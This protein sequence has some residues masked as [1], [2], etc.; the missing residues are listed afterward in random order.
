MLSLLAILV[1]APVQ[2][3]AISVAEFIKSFDDDKNRHTASKEMGEHI[4]FV[5]APDQSSDEIRSRLAEALSAS[6][7]KTESG[8]R[9]ERT[10]AQGEFLAKHEAEEREK[11]FRSFQEALR[12]R[13]ADNPSSE[14]RANAALQSLR[15][16][17]ERYRSTSPT[18]YTPATDFAADWL[19]YSLIEV[20]DPAAIAALPLM[21]DIQFSNKPVGSL[22]PLPNG[23]LNVL[24]I[25]GR[26]RRE[27]KDFSQT[28]LE[29]A[30][31][32]MSGWI[33]SRVESVSADKELDSV[34][35]QI[36]RSSNEFNAGVIVLDNKGEYFDAAFQ[37]FPS[38]EP[39]DRLNLSSL[40]TA[41]LNGVQRIFAETSYGY[42]FTRNPQADA[43]DRVVG[44]EPLCTTEPLFNAIALSTSR[45]LIAVLDDRLLEAAK[46]TPGH[47]KDVARF[48]R[49]AEDDGSLTW[50]NNNGWDVLRPR[51]LLDTEVRRFDRSGL[52]P[53]LEAVRKAGFETIEAHVDFAAAAPL[54]ANPVVT[55]VLGHLNRNG[56]VLV[57]EEL[58]PTWMA[59]VVRDATKLRGTRASDLTE[60][61]LTSLSAERRSEILDRARNALANLQPRPNTNPTPLEMNGDYALPNGLYADSNLRIVPSSEGCIGLS[62]PFPRAYDAQEFGYT[63]AL[64]KKSPAVMIAGPFW[65]GRRRT[66]QV[67]INLTKNGMIRCKYRESAD[68][69]VEIQTYESL[70]AEFRREAERYYDEARKLGLL[71]P[72]SLNLRGLDGS[73]FFK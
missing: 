46:A 2:D 14:E 5:H 65:Y 26:D 36:G 51:Y 34:I 64:S 48:V 55:A 35:L 21:A 59:R 25:Y 11:L 4:I 71:L 70:P 31:G 37:F 40:I 42:S 60:L 24:R 20:I 50:S 56:Y 7:R 19:L 39:K 22:R 6:W 73:E 43:I 41:E 61:P 10:N 30:E 18:S 17:Q 28:L 33:K 67:E 49:Y 27:I 72:A 53:F 23:A 57:Q 38:L 69:I 63:C 1:V 68:S 8:F 52:R 15:D 13:L 47:I 29:A 12:K 58:A 32:P 16:L 3:R 45:P 54:D 9:L 44:I 62:I 66:I